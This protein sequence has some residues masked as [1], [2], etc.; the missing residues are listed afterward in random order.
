MTEK[1]LVNAKTQITELTHDM[2]T[3]VDKFLYN[4]NHSAGIRT[5]KNLIKL[6][7]LYKKLRSD[8]LKISNERLKNKKE[9]KQIIQQS[10]NM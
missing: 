6:I 2:F 7:K 4:G 8:T 10:S 5:R 9:L 1:E 3:D